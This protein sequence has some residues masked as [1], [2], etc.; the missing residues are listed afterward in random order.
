[1]ADPVSRLFVARAWRVHVGKV[2]PRLLPHEA[3]SQEVRGFN[4]VLN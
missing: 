3:T 4:L 1:M 2:L